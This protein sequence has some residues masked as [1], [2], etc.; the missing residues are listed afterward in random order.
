MSAALERRVRQYRSRILIRQWD[1]RQRHH[2]SGV[3]FRFRRLL[4]DASRAYVVSPEDA[5]RLRAEG[6]R[7]ESVGALIEPPKVIV[8]APAHRVATLASA[9]EVP[10]SLGSE[11]LS[12]ACLVLVDFEPH[13]TAAA[14]GVA[15]PAR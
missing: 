5:E 1:Y 8:S 4:A 12:A 6:Y 10:V 11:L 7:T 9:R 2:A 13:P 15:N 3:W 14:D